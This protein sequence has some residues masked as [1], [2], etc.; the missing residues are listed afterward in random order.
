SAIILLFLFDP[1]QQSHYSFCLFKN[2]GIKFCPGC[3]LGH[4]ISW[5]LH[6]DLNASLKSHPL[7]IIALP[8]ILYR[9]FKLAKYN[10]ST[11]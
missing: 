3:G 11:I 8:V 10:L 9:I 1:S 7:G 5:L 4:S 2:L 6:G